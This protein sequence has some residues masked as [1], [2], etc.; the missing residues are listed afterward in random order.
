MNTTQS[1]FIKVAFLD[2]DGTVRNKSLM[3]TF[4][5]F[6]YGLGY[7]SR[8]VYEELQAKRVRYKSDKDNP[9]S[10]EEYVLLVSRVLLDAIK[11]LPLVKVKELAAQ[12]IAKYQYEDYRYTKRLIKS[13]RTNGYKIIAIS[14][15]LDFLVDAFREFYDFDQSYGHG[16]SID[17]NNIYAA[18]EPTTWRDKHLVIDQIIRDNGWEGVQLQSFAVGDTGGDF[19]MLQSVTYPITINPSK[20]LVKKMYVSATEDNKAYYCVIERKDLLYRFIITPNSTI[21]DGTIVLSDAVLFG[22]IMNLYNKSLRSIT[23]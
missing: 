22:V 3:E 19:T 7:I 9:D 5:D 12:A 11:G 14:G 18:T 10:Y 6:L 20:G 8:V 16:F 2:I 13:L 15:S 4:V 1:V 23:Q 17:K 21:K